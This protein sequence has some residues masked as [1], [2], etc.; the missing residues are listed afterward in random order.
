MLFLYHPIR[1][2]MAPHLLAIRV[3]WPH[4]K[5]TFTRIRQPF[6]VESRKIH[7]EKWNQD[8]TRIFT[9][10]TICELNCFLSY[11]RTVCPK[12]TFSKAHAPVTCI[13]M[14]RRLDWG[15]GYPIPGWGYPIL[16]CMGED[17]PHPDL[18]RG[19]TPWGIPP[20]LGMGYHCLGLGYPICYWGTPRKGPETR[21][22]G[23]PCQKGYRTSGSI[24]R[25]KWGTPCMWTD[26]NITSRRIRTQA[27]IITKR[28]N[29]IP[30]SNLTWHFSWTVF[31]MYCLWSWRYRCSR[32]SPWEGLRRRRALEPQPPGPPAQRSSCCSW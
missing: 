26:W 32:P 11:F 8:R 19:T 16:T 31:Q 10:S 20:H 25:W 22:W 28:D 27:V 1:N 24:M 13:L 5:G 15:R 14:Q 29:P 17:I 12:S 6:H 30:I 23:T 2:T 9:S 7:L 18:D 3:H 4:C 21:H